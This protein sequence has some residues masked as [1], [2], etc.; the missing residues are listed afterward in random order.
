MSLCRSL[1]ALYITSHQTKSCSCY[2]VVSQSV[3][4][5]N[6]ASPTTITTTTISTIHLAFSFFCTFFC[7]PLFTCICISPPLSPNI[8][9]WESVFRNPCNQSTNSFAFL[10]LVHQTTRRTICSNHN[11]IQI[12]LLSVTHCFILDTIGPL[13]DLGILAYACGDNPAHSTHLSLNV[14]LCL[15]LVSYET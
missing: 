10:Y 6:H 7:F 15:G 14:L 3:S 9:P 8:S 1:S 5:V 2:P 11:K 12:D 13:G 4:T